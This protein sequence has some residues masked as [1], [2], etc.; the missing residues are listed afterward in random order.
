ML[1]PI[2]PWE[3]LSKPFLILQVRPRQNLANV[4]IMVPF[5]SIPAS[6]QLYRVPNPNAIVSAIANSCF[7]YTKRLSSAAR[8]RNLSRAAKGNQ[9]FCSGHWIT[10]R[11]VRV[12][13]INGGDSA[14]NAWQAACDHVIP[15]NGID[16]YR[17]HH[18]TAATVAQWLA[19]G[20]GGSGGGP[21]PVA[22]IS[23]VFIFNSKHW[24]SPPFITC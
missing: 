23:L 9:I 6:I 15:A 14:L 13:A 16:S 5:H 20:H 1:P 18:A 12:V 8:E 4:I 19:R 7:H 21:R 2:S 11:P 22:R 24:V 17:I 3:W 10:G